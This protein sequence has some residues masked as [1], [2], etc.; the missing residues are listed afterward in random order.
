MTKLIFKCDSVEKK[1]DSSI[2]DGAGG[3]TY[4]AKFTFVNLVP[5]AGVTMPPPV[6]AFEMT[7]PLP[8]AYIPNIVYSFDFSVSQT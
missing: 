2:N 3:F 8:D 4:T 5:E 6:H 7:T 1:Y